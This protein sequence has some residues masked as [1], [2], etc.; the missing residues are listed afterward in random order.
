MILENKKKGIKT[1]KAFFAGKEYE[2][3]KRFIKAE[4]DCMLE[5]H[6]VSGPWT[7]CQ[8]VKKVKNDKSK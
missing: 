6:D 4:G 3:K 2:T 7:K 8:V 5:S 1:G